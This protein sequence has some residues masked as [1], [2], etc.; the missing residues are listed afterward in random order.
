[1][2]LKKLVFNV[3]KPMKTV[4]FV[5]VEETNKVKLEYQNK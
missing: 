1:M 2:L 4:S 3:Q 5:N